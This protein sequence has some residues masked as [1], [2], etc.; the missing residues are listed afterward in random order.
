MALRWFWTEEQIMRDHKEFFRERK[1]REKWKK[2]E[3]RYDQL[4]MRCHVS[5]DSFTTLRLGVSRQSQTKWWDRTIFRLQ[6]TTIYLGRFDTHHFLWYL[7]QHR[8]AVSLRTNPMAPT[9]MVLTGWPP[10]VEYSGYSNISTKNEKFKYIYFCPLSSPLL[11]CLSKTWPRVQWR[12]TH[13]SPMAG[14]RE[15]TD[16]RRETQHK[17][18]RA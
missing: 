2:L 3:R 11:L 15:K 17:G 12:E 16:G 7:S 18:L 9:L 5:Y 1:W 14:R 4:S 10:R 6:L 13:Q 8:V